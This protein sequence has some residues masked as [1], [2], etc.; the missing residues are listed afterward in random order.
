M[1]SPTA[2]LAAEGGKPVGIVS[3]GTRRRPKS[4][5]LSPITDSVPFR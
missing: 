4:A 5:R 2:A 1:T 3:I